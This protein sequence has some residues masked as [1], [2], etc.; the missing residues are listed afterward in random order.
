MKEKH[1]TPDCQT[2]N[3][4]PS[5]SVS[6]NKKPSTSCRRF[7]CKCCGTRTRT[8]NNR[9]RICCVANYTIPQSPV[10][11]TNKPCPSKCGA[12]VDVFFFLTKNFLVFFVK[13]GVFLSNASF[14]RPYT[15]SFCRKNRNF[16]VANAEF[17]FA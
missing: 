13:N 9:T 11:S 14:F 6:Q 16:A 5:L 3:S 10:A 7:F 8:L 4:L 2:S 1:S 17:H 15:N 12:K